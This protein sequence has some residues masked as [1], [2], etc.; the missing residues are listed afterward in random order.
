MPLPDRLAV[1]GCAGVYGSGRSAH[2]LSDHDFDWWPPRRSWQTFV[3]ARSWLNTTSSKTASENSWSPL[4][5]RTG[6]RCVRKLLVASVRCE[7]VELCSSEQTKLFTLSSLAYFDGL[8]GRPLYIGLCGRVYDVSGAEAY[9]RTTSRSSTS[10]L[11][12]GT[13]TSSSSSYGDLWGGKDA[14]F[15]LMTMSL[16]PR[17]VN[18]TAPFTTPDPWEQQGTSRDE[19]PGVPRGD[20]RTTWDRLRMRFGEAKLRG[21]LSW[22]GHFEKKYPCVGALEEY[23]SVDFDAVFAEMVEGSSSGKSSSFRTAVGDENV[24]L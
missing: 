20:S 23:E 11:S 15:A 3:T 19:A 7:E 13:T 14:T 6:R 16:D 22:R 24:V 2:I 21:L 9:K 10:T 8:D 12:G 17:H 4:F 5:S 1:L 18:L